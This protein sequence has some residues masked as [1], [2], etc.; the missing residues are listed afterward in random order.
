M[1]CKVASNGLARF[2]LSVHEEAPTGAP[3]AGGGGLPDIDGFVL[4]ALL[5]GRDALAM[6]RGPHWQ[7]GI[8]EATLRPIAENLAEALRRAFPTLASQL[9]KSSP[10]VA[11]VMGLAM[12]IAPVIAYE[13]MVI[14]VQRA[15]QPTTPPESGNP[16]A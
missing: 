8:P 6:S 10:L 2:A 12:A 16:Y 4:Y 5:S 14:N 3:I 1:L 15:G 11:G 9:E 7:E 13:R